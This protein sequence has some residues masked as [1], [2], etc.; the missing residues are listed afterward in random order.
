MA[1]ELDHLDGTFEVIVS[2]D[3][4]LDCTVE[5]YKNYLDTL[6][7]KHLKFKAGQE[8][9]RFV[10]KKQLDWKSGAALKKSMAKVTFD[11][12]GQQTEFNMAYQ[13]EEIRYSLVDIKNPAG[14]PVEKQIKFVKDSDGYVSK[15]LVM[16]LD[17][18]GAVSEMVVAKQAAVKADSENLKKS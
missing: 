1:L 14:V 17:S 16:K 8:P 6:D 9:T 18:I 7:E 3:K 2:K 12:Q 4:A 11:G 10:L 5:D 15:D 13:L